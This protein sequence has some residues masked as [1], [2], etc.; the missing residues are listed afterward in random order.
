[1]SPQKMRTVKGLGRSLRRRQH[2]RLT[3]RLQSF[4]S[5]DEYDE[6]AAAAQTAGVSVSRWMAEIAI[7]EA[8]NPLARGQR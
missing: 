5:Q 3:C 1:M 7:R 8:R 2:K 6:I 4:V